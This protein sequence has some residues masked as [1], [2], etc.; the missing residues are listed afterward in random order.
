MKNKT[1]ILYLNYT[2]FLTQGILRSQVGV[3]LKKLG[4]EGF[5][6]ILFSCERLKDFFKRDEIKKIKNEF[7]SHNVNI[8]FLPKLLPKYLQ[9]V[10]AYIR[11]G[12]F[13]IPFILDLII[14]LT[15]AFFITLTNKPKII[16]TRSYVPAAIGVLLKKV[17][18]VKL[19]FDPRGIIPEELQFARGWNE[20]DTRYKIW[21]KIEKWILKN[22]D[23]VFALSEPFKDHLKKIAPDEEIL[24]TPCSVDTD[25]FVFD[26]ERREILR[27][28]K[29][30]SDKF[31]ILYSIGC[32]VPYQVLEDAVR[33]YK[34][35]KEIKRNSILWICTPDEEQITIYFKEK[36]LFSD[37]IKIF[38]AEFSEMPDVNL[39]ADLGLLVRHQSIVSKVA[40]PVKFAEYLASGL[41]VACYPE[42]GDTEKIIKENNVGFI[43]LPEDEEVTKRNIKEF[44]QRYEKDEQ[45]IKKRC[46]EIAK[47]ILSINSVLKI[48]RD[49][50]IK[51]K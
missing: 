35:I 39:A 44:I 10:P 50:Y 47:N 13:I 34:Y 29:N 33:I 23:V 4:D 49:I 19:I 43:L 37:D 41:P 9:I 7:K 18:N 42:I 2:S 30:V 40:S 5:S 14:F 22:S 32:F 27:K 20:N 3:P 48:Y 45:N 6:F 12:T 21:K 24:I 17:F 28:E 8:I 26:S 51:L 38:K 1:P 31:V 46:S 15:T 36:N 11:K 16:H 25:I